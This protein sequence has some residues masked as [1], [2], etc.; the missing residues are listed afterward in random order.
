MKYVIKICVIYFLIW[1][2]TCLVYFVAMFLSVGMD[3]AVYA[4]INVYDFHL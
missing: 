3:V 2:P 1:D 4:C